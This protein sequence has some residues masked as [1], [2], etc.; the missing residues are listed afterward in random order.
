MVIGEIGESGIGSGV[1]QSG[2]EWNKNNKNK[3]KGKM[4]YHHSTPYQRSMSSWTNSAPSVF[5]LVVSA[6]QEG[7]FASECWGVCD[8]SPLQDQNHCLPP[9]GVGGHCQ[10]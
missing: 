9:V 5:G 2:T 3:N 4:R 8:R 6:Q 1:E 10:S 7:R